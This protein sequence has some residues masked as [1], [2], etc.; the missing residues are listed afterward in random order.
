MAHALTTADTGYH[1]LKDFVKYCRV[2]HPGDVESNVHLSFLLAQRSKNDVVVRYI[3]I[4]K[5]F[6]VLDS[7]FLQMEY[8][9]TLP[10][11]QA[12]SYIMDCLLSFVSGGLD[13]D[14]DASP[15]RENEWAAIYQMLMAWRQLESCPNDVKLYCTAVLVVL[16]GGAVPQALGASD[17]TKSVDELFGLIT[18][19]KRS[20]DRD[21]QLAELD[22][23]GSSVLL[24]LSTINER[25]SQ[26]ILKHVYLELLQVVYQSRAKCLQISPVPPFVI[27]A[28]AL[29]SPDLI[30]FC[31]ATLTSHFMS[32]EGL[33][34]LLS[35]YA[36]AFY[37]Y[38]GSVFER[39][40]TGSKTHLDFADSLQNALSRDQKH[41]HPTSTASPISI[42]FTLHPRN[43][44]EFYSLTVF[45]LHTAQKY[46]IVHSNSSYTDAEAIGLLSGA[47][48]AMTSQAIEGDTAGSAA[49]LY[50]DLRMRSM[51][52]LSMH[53]SHPSM[54]TKIRLPFELLAPN[55][56]R[57]QDAST[58]DT[59]SHQLPRRPESA[60][61]STI[62][63]LAFGA[64]LP[65]IAASTTSSL[66]IAGASVAP[67]AEVLESEFA[68]T[69]SPLE[70]AL[71]T[72]LCQI[73]E[74]I[75]QDLV[76]TV[77]EERIA[78]R[79]AGCLGIKPKLLPRDAH[80][81]SPGAGR[82]QLV[83]EFVRSDLVGYIN[84]MQLQ[85]GS[86]GVRDT[87]LVDSLRT[88]TRI[89]NR[90]LT[91]PGQG[92][93]DSDR[94]IAFKRHH[95][96]KPLTP[97]G[98]HL[99]QPCAPDPAAPTHSPAPKLLSRAPIAPLLPASA[100]RATSPR[101]VAFQR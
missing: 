32:R 57:G 35:H 33:H 26:S 18:N 88:L 39:C 10:D 76:G 6:D 66:S 23:M 30:G 13:S 3:L 22:G 53:Y 71:F 25:P 72:C 45:V 91:Y 82:I 99:S 55:L 81:E 67:A 40:F 54:W 74:A 36:A 50:S 80:G 20:F 58:A 59:S 65:P 85:A 7:F 5:E 62:S 83:H 75:I 73:N 31:E 11:L 61:R 100:S 12:I 1:I 96:L 16:Q 15:T 94:G 48:V 38:A 52:T 93:R 14:G 2:F 84:F 43:N 78:S 56:L 9:N 8:S 63:Q 24:V 69:S 98:D 51:E 47:L 4:Q 17:S 21:R 77:D 37:E 42:P 87:R 92:T 89:M 95:S 97:P 29:L 46:M 70:T 101:K 49:A 27:S 28:R 64:P 34:L 44:A 79:S 19:D 86:V 60:S 90:S 68:A 41:T